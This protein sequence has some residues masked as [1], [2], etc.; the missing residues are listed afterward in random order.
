MLLPAVMTGWIP[1]AMFER[2]PTWDDGGMAA[3]EWL[4]IVL[5][6]GGLCA[7]ASCAWQFARK[8]RGTVAPWDGPRKLV[9]RGLYRWVRNPMYISLGVVVA[10]EAIYFESWRIGLY[11]LCLT[12]IAQLAVVLHEE[13]E[14]SFRY[15]AMYEDY[16]RIVP[17]WFP[18]RP[19]PTAFELDSSSVER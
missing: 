13:P 1:L 12:C 5:A 11:L 17:R 4:A 16:K 14:M 6:T 2:Y 8:G 19:R 15:G 7:Y 10:S 9:Q 18:R 3:H